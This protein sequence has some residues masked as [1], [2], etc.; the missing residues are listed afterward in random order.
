VVVDER[1]RLIDVGGGA[2]DVGFR[3]GREREKH[4][5]VTV[6][7]SFAICDFPPLSS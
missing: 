3:G 4:E 1:D 2:R 5:C 7:R 6:R